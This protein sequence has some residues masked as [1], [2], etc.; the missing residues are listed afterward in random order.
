MGIFD[1]FKKKVPS[2]SEKLDWAYRCF[3][4]DAVGMVFPGGKEQAERVI[5]SLGNICDV[6]L[7]L[8]DE[9][10]YFD[11]LKVYS[12]IILRRALTHSSN[13]AIVESLLEKYSDSI[14]DKET[15]QRVLAYVT[16]NMQDHN[17]SLTTDSDMIKLDLLSKVFATSEEL[18]DENK[19]A[20]KEYLGDPEYGLVVM[21]PIYTHGVEG[22]REFLE[23]LTTSL[24]EELTWD[25]VG[26]TSREGI[27][28]AIDIYESTLPSGKPYKT[29]YLNMYGAK[30][31]DV[32]PKGFKKG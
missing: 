26:S 25:R 29:L 8:C 5:L 7:E 17:Y 30:N 6:D 18:I 24:G 20:E 15:A 16:L 28:G 21:K 27:N 13:E 4:P 23:S 14:K 11:L 9:T 19:T 32:I 31:S 2:H 22:S 10:K 12:T 3:K 1:F